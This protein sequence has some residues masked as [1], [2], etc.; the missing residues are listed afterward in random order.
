ELNIP[1]LALIQVSESA[2]YRTGFRKLTG[3]GIIDSGTAGIIQVNLISSCF[4]ISSTATLEVTSNF[5][6]TARRCEVVISICAFRSSQIGYFGIVRKCRSRG[7]G[8]T[9]TSH[10]FFNQII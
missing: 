10:S 8:L 2:T 9:A 1:V 5:E 4:D 6:G 3:I 7:G